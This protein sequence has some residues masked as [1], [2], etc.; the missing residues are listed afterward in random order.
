MQMAIEKKSSIA[1]RGTSRLSILALVLAIIALVL[2]IV[3]PMQMQ[4]WPQGPQGLQGIQGPKGAPGGLV[5]GTPI[6]YGPYDFDIGTA[7][8]YF[9]IASVNPG[10]RV[11]FTFTVSGSDVHYWVEDPWYNHILT[12]RLGTAVSEGAGSF[13]ASSSGPYLLH[14]SSTG[15]VTPS[16]LTIN[17]TVYP[18]EL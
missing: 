14:F 17:Y 15:L 6:E 7:G 18:V 10:D 5:W 8:D 13:I 3:L 2:A 16:V 11:E 9:S 12:G 1:N 4:V